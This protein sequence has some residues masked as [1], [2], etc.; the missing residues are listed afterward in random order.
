MPAHG[1]DVMLRADAKC[2]EEQREMANRRFPEALAGLR[3]SVAVEVQLCRWLGGALSGEIFESSE[4]L[5][6]ETHEEILGVWC[7]GDGSELPAFRAGPVLLDPHQHRVNT[8]DHSLIRT[9][10][11]LSGSFGVRAQRRTRRSDR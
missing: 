10:G 8:H 2:I 1:V 11:D 9:A 6:D 5:V 4:H 7:D 3:A